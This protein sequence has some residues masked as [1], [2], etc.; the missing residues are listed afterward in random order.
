MKKFLGVL[1]EWGCDTKGTYAKTIMEKDVKN[2][3]E[4][5]EKYTGSEVKVQK[6]P[7]A[8]DTIIIK[9]DLEEPYNIDDCR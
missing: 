8:T 2:I 7:R 9:S 4:G 6:T 5:Y 3:I 1:Y